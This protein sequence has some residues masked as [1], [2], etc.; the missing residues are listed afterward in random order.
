MKK[1]II[2]VL[3]I[4]KL[5]SFGM[6]TQLLRRTLVTKNSLP[7]KPC[8]NSPQRLKYNSSISDHQFSLNRESLLTNI[9]FAHQLMTKQPHDPR[10]F[11]LFFSCHKKLILFRTN[12]MQ[13]LAKNNCFVESIATAISTTGAISLGTLSYLSS[14]CATNSAIAAMATGVFSLLA[15][16]F[17]LQ[18]LTESERLRIAQKCHE[19]IDNNVHVTTSTTNPADLSKFSTELYK[20]AIE[21]IE[22]AAQNSIEEN[23]VRE[24][25]DQFFADKSDIITASA[26]NRNS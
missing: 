11:E 5:S 20:H 26:L 3:C 2:I 4:I 22:R 21:K 19:I 16:G 18:T 1:L 15:A 8:F 13:E 12:H 6:H 23:I 14:S 24:L 25:R 17:G 7:S 9:Q 10:N